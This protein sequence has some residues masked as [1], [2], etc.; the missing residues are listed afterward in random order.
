MRCEL[1]DK[2]QFPVAAKAKLGHVQP[3]EDLITSKLA[4]LHFYQLAVPAPKPEA[5][6][7]DVAAVER[8]EKVFNGPGKCASC[9]VPPLF[10]EPGW[11]MHTAEEIGIDEFQAS[12]SPDRR[13][14]TTPLRGLLA[15]AGVRSNLDGAPLEAGRVLL[16]CGAA[17]PAPYLVEIRGRGI[18]WRF[19]FYQLLVV[20]V[21]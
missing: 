12:R 7:F 13:Y 8:G 20:V 3:K 2:E 6:S 11:S 17:R 1:D 19:K 10:T 4:A 15:H 21:L 9:H 18:S 14:R 16:C 5:G